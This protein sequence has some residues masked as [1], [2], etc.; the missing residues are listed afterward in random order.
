M[1]EVLCVNYKD[2]DVNSL[3]FEKPSIQ[4]SFKNNGLAKY[5]KMTVM[6]NYDGCNSYPL[7]L[8]GPEMLS[9]ISLSSHDNNKLPVLFDLHNMDHIYYIGVLNDLYDSIIQAFINYV[10]ILKR[11]I[12][13]DEELLSSLNSTTMKDIIYDDYV[14]SIQ[15]YESIHTEKETKSL[16][17]LDTQGY[18]LQWDQL[19]NTN[20]TYTPILK[21]KSLYYGTSENEEVISVRA[22]MEICNNVNI[23]N[24]NK[25]EKRRTIVIKKLNR[26][27]SSKKKCGVNVNKTFTNILSNIYHVLSYIGIIIINV[28]KFIFVKFILSTLRKIYN[29]LNLK[30]DEQI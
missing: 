2:F 21:I 10:K 17:F 24:K 11:E 1:L 20:I 23:I 9:Y 26:V 4:L 14:T 12:D 29:V 3:S 18:E 7:M 6:Y 27:A 25:N 13:I 8:Q 15:Y 16:K 5:I 22:Y 30:N 28:V 19:H